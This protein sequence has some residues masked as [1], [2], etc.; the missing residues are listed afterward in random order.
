MIS[1]FQEVSD[2]SMPA[3]ATEQNWKLRVADKRVCGR[4][5]LSSLS[6]ASGYELSTLL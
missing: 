3:A 6:G 2:N 1:H 5:Q 4:E